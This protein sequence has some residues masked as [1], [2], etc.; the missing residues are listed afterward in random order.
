MTEPDLRKC[1]PAEAHFQLAKAWQ[2]KGNIDSAI[3]RYQQA[4][5][6]KPD[7]VPALL[8]LGLLM[9]TTGSTKEALDYYEKALTLSPDD[10]E[11]LFR[12]NYIKGLIEKKAETQIQPV[13]L[14]QDNKFFVCKENP[15]GKID[16]FNQKTFS[17]HR[18]GWNYAL[19]ALMPLHNRKGILFDGF[20]EDNFAWKH[21]REGIR[22]PD[23]LNRMKIDG[24]FE[25]LATSEERG[26]TP[27]KRPWVGFLHNP[28]GMPT[29][30]HYQESPQSIF[31]K[32]IWQQSVEYCLGLFTFS[33]YH[34][35]WLREQTGKPVSVLTHPTEA[36][37][38]RFDFDR[39][40]AN[41][42]KKIVQVGWWLRKL[43]AIYQLPI[44]SNNPLEY[45]KIRLI[46]MFFDNADEY[47]KKLMEKEVALNQL[48]M[49]PLF[50]ENTKEVRHISNNDYDRL[51]SENI[52]FV[53]LY[54]SNANNLV[55]EC[56]A[57]GTPLLINPL[58]AVVEYLGQDYP[59]YFNSLDEAAEISL[60]VSL[61]FDTHIYLQRCQTAKELSADYF[62]S[63]FKESKVYKE[64]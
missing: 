17:C 2:L 57:R 32:G 24:T 14:T 39:F 40:V 23:V 19:H 64:L 9:L 15:E 31:A 12:R 25:E 45:E 54:D 59:M 46:P 11:V 55:I 61:I 4:L 49:D 5:R 21:W 1:D 18:S 13:V 41:P 53:D 27:Y 7:Y 33:E 56:I 26:I 63:S 52:A 28:Q 34:A 48:T 6:C 3:A 20:I 36:P 43:N 58:P 60:N 51:L 38:L 62:L 10:S 22:P 8:Q 44:A 29:W 47:L 37:E 42:Q 50:S 30:F 16:I 35:Q